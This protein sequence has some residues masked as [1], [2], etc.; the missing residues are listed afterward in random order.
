MCCSILLQHIHTRTI[1]EATLLPSDFKYI[2]F[3]VVNGE[4]WGYMFFRV[5]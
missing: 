4:N 3:L 5:G 2:G 1:H